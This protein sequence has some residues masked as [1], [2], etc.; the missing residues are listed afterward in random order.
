MTLDDLLGLLDHTPV[1][2]DIHPVS[3][4]YLPREVTVLDSLAEA[5]WLLDDPEPMLPG[6]LLITTS[7]PQYSGRL[8]H[9]HC[10]HDPFTP[11]LNRILFAHFDDIGS[12]M[13]RQS[14][15]ADRIAADAVEYD[16][17]IL[18]LVDGLSYQDVRGWTSSFGHTLSIEPCLVD[19]P[20]LTRLAFPNL[21]GVPSLAGRLFDAGYHSRLGFTY[22]A[23]EDNELTDRMFQAIAEVKKC[24]HFPQ[25]LTTLRE[26]V[27]GADQTK[28]YIQ[29]VRTGLDSYAHGQKRKPPVTAIVEEVHQEFEQLSALC[30]DLCAKTGLRAS[31]YVTA[32]HGIL[33]RDESELE[34]VG[35]A[36]ANSSPRWCGWR[37]LYHQRDQGRRFVIQG[38]EYYCLGFSK[39]RRQLRIDEQGVHGGISFQ[40]S[41][42]PFVTH[43]FVSWSGK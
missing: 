19:V 21:I 15:I 20:T 33:W 30:S 2:A 9:V 37:D 31:L 12:R 38:E 3:I 14:Q 4:Y 34:I 24:G 25:I 29:I 22:W 35:H 41:I 18:L 1:I 10:D 16:L 13:L 43:K 42:V 40:E 6:Q 36:L 23:R 39:L 8:P 17:V 11:D 28:T 32:D 27:T 5:A 26:Y 7:E